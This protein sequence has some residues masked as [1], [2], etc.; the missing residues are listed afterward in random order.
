M[1]WINPDLDERVARTLAKSLGLSPTIGRILLARGIDSKGEASQFLEPRLDSLSDPLRV[2]HLPAAVERVRKAL[3]RQEKVLIFG[4][5]DVDGITSTAML[6]DFLRFWGCTARYI[7]PRRLKEGYGLSVDALNRALEEQEPD[8][9]I[10]VD[11]GTSSANE[12]RFL[13]DKGIDVLILDHHKSKE[14]LPSDCIIVNPHVFDPENAPWHDMCSVGLVFKFTHGF[15]KVLRSEGDAIANEINLEEY[16]D[17]VALGTVADLVQLTGENRILVHHGL[18]RIRKCKR[19]GLCA[20]MEVC[21][22]ALGESTSPFDVAFRL[23][24]RINASGRLDDAS[25]PIQLLLSEDWRNASGLAQQLDEFNTERQSIERAIAAEAEAMVLGKFPN[26]NIFVLFNPDWHGGVVGIVA[27]RIARKFNRP[28]I[29]L[30]SAEDG[31]CKGSGRSI[32]GVNLVETLQSCDSLIDHWGG[33]PMAVGLTIEIEK[34]DALRIGLEKRLRA[35][36]SS[37]LP[38]PQLFL[39]GQL[40][41][42]ELT[43]DLLDEI[44]QLAPFGQGNEEPVFQL[45]KVRVRSVSSMGASHLRFYVDCG[46]GHHPI[47]GIGWNFADNPMPVRE[48]VDLAVRFHWNYWRGRKSPR[49]TLLDWHLP[50]SS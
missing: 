21:G 1:I 32:F 45:S 11:C 13:R 48:P 35:D 2:T 33:H 12:V 15:L 17:L 43:P 36:F 5:Y 41:T 28:T 50:A 19:P 18:Q 30:G 31:F 14:A 34:V 46:N 40:S 37:D 22:M 8:L 7:V 29:V 3:V 16:L 27:S 6:T 10:A 9:L 20:L 25:I 24:P 38:E 49:L 4:D 44:D 42:E 26:D 47:E 23:G 39:D